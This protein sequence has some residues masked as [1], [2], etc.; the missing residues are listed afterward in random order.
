MNTVALPRRLFR[1]GGM[2][3][4]EHQLSSKATEEKFPKET[5]VSKVVKKK[6]DGG[7]QKPKPERI[8]M[9]E[10]CSAM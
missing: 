4:L 8:S 2:G 5:E 6:V 1:L 7:S 3:A 9:G 10:A